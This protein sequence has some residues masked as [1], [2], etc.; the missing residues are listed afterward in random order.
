MR[1]A[2]LIPGRGAHQDAIEVLSDS[3]RAQNASAFQ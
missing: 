3:H 2:I 1:T